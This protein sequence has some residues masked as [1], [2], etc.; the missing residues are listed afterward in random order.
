MQSAHRSEI[1]A[2]K[3]V[4][5]AAICLTLVLGGQAMSDHAGPRADGTAATAIGRTGFAYLS[6]FRTYVAAVLWNR[7]DP[8]MH[9]Y[10]G[11][12]SFRKM[13]YMVPTIHTVVALDPNL[14]DPYYVGAWIVAANGHVEEGVQMARDGAEANPKSGLLRTSYAQMLEVWG[15]DLP[16]AYKQAVLAMDSDMQ[17]R[18]DFEHHDSLAIIS[19]ILRLYG[20]E[21]R[22]AWVDA[23]KERLDVL[24]G[25]STPAGTHD[26]DG[27]EVPDH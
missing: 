9:T 1:S 14:V 3:A 25:D 22:A 26:H 6:G 2:R 8:I 24:L 5:L 21:D 15:D 18:D 7:L 20:D 10:Y 27:D 4:I 11:G 17:W 12:T 23:E 16:G 13:T 19:S